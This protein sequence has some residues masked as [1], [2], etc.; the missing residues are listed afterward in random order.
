MASCTTAE[1]ALAR[2]KRRLERADVP[3]ATLVEEGAP[4]EAIV[5]AAVEGQFDLIVMGTRGRAALKQLFAGSTAEH[6]VRAATTPV[7]TIHPPGQDPHE[8]ASSP[9][10]P[11]AKTAIYG[12]L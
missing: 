1:D 8:T 11:D 6:V 4:V 5:H 3:I 2:M 7:L 12:R 9:V 10:T